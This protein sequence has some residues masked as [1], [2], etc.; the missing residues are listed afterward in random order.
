MA[1]GDASLGVYC[2]SV[3][4]EKDGDAFARNAACGAVGGARSLGAGP[5][6][7]DLANPDGAVGADKGRAVGE[8]PFMG[9]DTGKETGAFGTAWIALEGSV[10]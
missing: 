5:C 1:L 2:E 3:A 6:I 10:A 7:E 8:G 4:R 9:V